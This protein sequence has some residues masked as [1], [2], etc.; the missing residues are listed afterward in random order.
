MKLITSEQMKDIDRRASQDYLLPSLILM[1]NAG[2]RVVETIRDLIGDLPRAKIVIL[3]GRGNNGGDGMVVA[4]HLLNAGVRVETFLLGES[5]QLTGDAL[6]NYRI[7]EKM[8]APLSSLNNAADLENLL[9]SLLKADLIVDAIYGIGFRGSLNDFETRVVGLV[10][11]C[12]IPVVAVDIP[13]GVEA[14]TGKVH[15]IAV[16]ASHTVTLALPKLGLLL[17]PGRDYAGQVTIADISIPRQLLEDEQLKLNL[18]DTAMIQRHVKPRRAE[19]HKGT[20]GHALVIGGAAGM[21][22]AVMMTAYAALRSGAGL[23]TAALPESLV[24]VFEAAVQEVM[25]LPLAETS[26]STI[27]LEALPVLGNL[28]G[29]VSVCAI[30]PGMSRYQEANAILRF[31]LENTGVPILIDADGLNALEGD[32]AILKDRQVPIVITPHP[33]EMARLTGLT[34]DEIQHNRLETARRF[35]SAWGVTVVLKGH[36]TIVASPAGEL[37]INVTGNPGMATAGSGDVLSGIITGLMAQGL[38]AT[39]AAVVG[40]YIHG[41]CGDRAAAL[42]GQRGLVAGDLMEYLPGILCELEDHQ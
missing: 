9:L 35:A 16:R 19:S 36:N 24:P 29:T 39:T 42:T 18:I 37:F 11:L 40:V 5:T 22:G 15:G 12:R 2:L 8:A 30:G 17:E 32:V 7:L 6:I 23:V 10:N 4:R 31:V 25:S 13:S 33:G 14:D 28:L 38:R 41:C 20:Y 3:A 1:E 21:T 26:A 34:V 27:S